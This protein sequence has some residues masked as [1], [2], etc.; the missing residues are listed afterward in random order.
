MMIAP[1]SEQPHPPA[2]ALRAK[3]KDPVGLDQGGESFL[4]ATMF[5][6]NYLRCRRVTQ[7]SF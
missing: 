7:I 1:T 3:Q 6:T 2:A 4:L 5:L